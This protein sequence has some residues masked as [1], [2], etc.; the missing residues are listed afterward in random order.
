MMPIARAFS[1]ARL[2][3]IVLN[4]PGSINALYCPLIQQCVQMVIMDLTVLKSVATIVEFH[5]DATE[6]Q[7][8][9][10]VDVRLDG[11]NLNV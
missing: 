8:N 5:G 2:K 3:I 9:V 6:Q 7:E 11:N 10:M 4:I 1:K